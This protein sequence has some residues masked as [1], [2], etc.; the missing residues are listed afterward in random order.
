VDRKHTSLFI[1]ENN[2]PKLPKYKIP[3]T[4]GGSTEDWSHP[5]QRIPVRNP[6]SGHP[7][8]QTQPLIK[9]SS[10][11][12]KQPIERKVSSKRKNELDRLRN[13]KLA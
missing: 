9:P 6:T 8:P 2:S 5:Q 12:K 13:K 3:G 1:K 10:E 4:Q 7:S 11:T